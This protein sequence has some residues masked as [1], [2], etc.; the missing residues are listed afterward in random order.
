MKSFTRTFS[1]LMFTA[2]LLATQASFAATPT[3]NLSQRPQGQ[4]LIE[5]QFG[6]FSSAH[7]KNND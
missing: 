2:T 1:A 3:Q 6:L 5:Y 7:E 4:S